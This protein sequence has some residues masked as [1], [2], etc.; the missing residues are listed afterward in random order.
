[1]LK[2]PKEKGKT[3]RQQRKATYARDR[4]LVRAAAHVLD[5]GRCIWPTCRRVVQLRA[6]DPYLLANAHELVYRSKL[7]SATDLTNVVTLCHTCHMDLH[8]PVG[9]KKKRMTGTSRATL[10]FFEKRSTGDWVEVGLG[11]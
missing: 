6:D 9:G 7:G 11:Q 5:D 10:R 8:T 4:K 1:M 2:F 3:R